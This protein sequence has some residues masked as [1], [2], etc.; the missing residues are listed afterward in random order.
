MISHASSP[1]HCNTSGL[2]EGNSSVVEGAGS[3]VECEN[4]CG[5]AFTDADG[6]TDDSHVRFHCFI[7]HLHF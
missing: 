1:Q 7:F 6:S 4:D 2:E 5:S 3:E